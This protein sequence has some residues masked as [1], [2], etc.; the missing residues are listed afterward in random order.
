MRTAWRVSGAAKGV[1]EGGGRPSGYFTGAAGI[2]IYR[3]DAFP[4]EYLGDAFIADCGSNLIHR[5]K[6]RG[7]V[8]LTAER[9]A[10]EQKSEFASSR[11]NWC[12]PVFFA[13]ASDGCLWFCDMYRE[14]IEHPWSL[15]EPLKSHLD[16]NSGN[17]RGR[18]W[19]L[20]PDGYQ[21]RPL[22]RLSNL[23]SGELVA[24]LAHP[25]G[26][27]RD[28]AARLLHQRRD[29]TAAPALL[30]LAAHSASPLGRVAALRVLAGN[31]ALDE[32]V[33]AAVL[34]DG[35]AN[36][37][38]QALRL[39]GA[40]Y[41]DEPLPVSIDAALSRLAE[42]SSAFVRYE[43]AWALGMLSAKD[44][45]SL[46]LLLARRDVADSWARTALLAAAGEQAGELFRESA[47]SGD[48]AHAAFARELAALIGTRHR[49][50]DVGAVLAQAV[51]SPE[52]T[53]WLLPLAE[54]LSRGGSSL[55]KADV[56][57][58]LSPL[59]SAAEQRVRDRIDA[60]PTDFTLLSIA[61]SASAADT[62]G[63]AL[64]DGLPS[65]KASA[66]LAA[67][68]SLNPPTLGEI[69]TGAWPKLPA[70]TR[71]TALHL[72]RSRPQQV[73]ALL[74]AIAA[75]VVAKDEISA[76]DLAA[77]RESKDAAV[78]ARVVMLFGAGAS[79]EQALAA[80]RPALTL[81]GDSAKGHTT[82]QARCAVCHRLHNE[83][84][85]VGPQLEASAAAGREKLLG[86]ILDPSREITAGFGMAT[87]ETK[88][89]ELIAGVVV[90]EID[91]A[92]TL[93]LP[94]G[95]LRNLARLDVARIERSSRS[96]MPDGL[97]A[98]LTP[99]DMADLLEY[100][101]GH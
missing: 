83:G 19:R 66:A 93:R 28:T 46:L 29:P 31:N 84:N 2:T 38:A 20:V 39:L 13:N 40:K 43:L 53:A 7:E 8:L 72:W 89:G 44:K 6:L 77:L 91:G 81:K 68:G 90:A 15:P 80:F 3:G 27:H 24:L 56:E 11:D 95:L 73:P 75:R 52:P 88:S 63:R 26:W 36:V 4:T 55:A 96:L 57:K 45:S 87:V 48:P 74:D 37:R 47:R 51:A 1:I 64:E 10:D 101:A 49:D 62:I 100:L 99:Q 67:L 22:P 94:G 33:I 85:S 30:E 21:P 82:F 59:V 69:L 71:P 14:V 17:D 50:A 86:N 78:Q 54:G 60:R 76:E 9:A 16:L 97:E 58:K 65:A 92:V 12:R 61:G 35:D 34:M 42:D 18:L 5:K 70:D 32:I 41:A 98:G 23:S 79:R 25:N